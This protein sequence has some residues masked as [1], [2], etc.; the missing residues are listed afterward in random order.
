MAH[1]QSGEYLQSRQAFWASSLVHLH[2]GAR[3]GCSEVSITCPWLRSSGP[4]SSSTGYSSIPWSTYQT[5][6][7]P[8]AFEPRCRVPGL[9]TGLPGVPGRKTPPATL[10]GVPVHDRVSTLAQNDARCL[11]WTR[12]FQECLAWIE[13]HLLA[14]LTTN[15]QGQVS[16]SH[17]VWCVYNWIGSVGSSL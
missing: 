16:G 15:R 3:K 5:Q 11:V 14:S 13:V 2:T 12:N 1:Q 10:P 7:S 6:I 17:S 9:D 4:N 8:Q